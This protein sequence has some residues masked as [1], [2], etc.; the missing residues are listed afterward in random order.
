MIYFVNKI[1]FF[2]DK[3]IPSCMLIQKEGILDDTRYKPTNKLTVIH[4]PIK[5]CGSWRNAGKEACSV[6][7][8]ERR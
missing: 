3:E 5:K 7:N 8:D 1:K 2:V 4:R 6:V